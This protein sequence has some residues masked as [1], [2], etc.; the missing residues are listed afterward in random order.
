[1]TEISFKK[2]P[3]G[4]VEVKRSMSIGDTFV[5]AHKTMFMISIDEDCYPLYYL[6]LPS[7]PGG[8]QLSEI[9]YMELSQLL[10]VG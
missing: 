5:V 2:L 7:H 1:M 10:L 4:F 9:E 3:G 8:I 6:F